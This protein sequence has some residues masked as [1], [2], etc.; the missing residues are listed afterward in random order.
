MYEIQSISDF[1]TGAALIVRIPESDIDKKAF[2]TI[3]T[4][5]PDFILPFRHRSVDGQIEF[6][7]QIGARSKLTYL[8]GDRTPYEYA[9][10][11]MGVLQPLLDCGDWFMNPY[12]FVLKPEFIYCEKDKYAASY[13]YIP[14]VHAYSNYDTLKNMV[15]EIAKQNHVLDVNL[16]NKVVWAIQDFSPN[17]FIQLL[18]P[19]SI[20]KQTET[21]TARE[22]MNAGTNAPAF[23]STAAAASAVP[24]PALST[25]ISGRAAGLEPS[26]LNTS[27]QPDTHI[28]N[29]QGQNQQAQSQREL[30]RQESNLPEG[31]QSAPK[32]SIFNPLK[33]G[34]HKPAEAIKNPADA[35]KLSDDISINLPS[36]AKAVKEKA[37]KGKTV[38]EKAV[39]EKTVKE[40]TVKEKPVKEKTA[41]EIKPKSVFFSFGNKEK[42]AKDAAPRQERKAKG[43]F[44]GKKIESPQDIVQGAAAEP[45]QQIQHSQQL[46]TYDPSP[47]HPSLPPID[48]GEDFTQ[49]EIIETDVPKF[50]YIG[51]GGHPKTINVQIEQ[52]GIFTIGRFDASLGIKQSSFEF[53]KRTKA[54]SR[55]HAAV[56]RD[57]NGY[58]IVDLESSA[59]TFINGIK[60]PSNTPMVLENGCRVS[61]GHSGADYVWEG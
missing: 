2:Y 27:I 33:Q 52:G 57:A 47:S 23:A 37:I 5:Q 8:Y 39:K 54:V 4:D 13:V 60:L 28:P 29:Q 3:L 12:A 6:T 22:Y 58:I 45:L 48:I 25:P 21:A 19:Y 46:Q 61:F 44:F 32:K 31:D 40:K 50:R 9:N 1:Q 18:K 53:D 35:Y 15:I 11:W 49:L 38:K 24:A 7:Y 10:L 43:I 51:G 30:N 20:S 36:K 55:R 41:N 56:E 17:S 26:A 59:G 42:S 34:T 14:S 16:E